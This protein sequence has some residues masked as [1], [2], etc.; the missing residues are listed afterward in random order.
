MVAYMLLCNF[1]D[2]GVRTIKDAPK[3]RTA[4]RQ[5][6]KKLGV[7]VKVSYLA[8]GPYDLVIQVEA[9]NDEALATYLLSLVVREERRSQADLS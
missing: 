9:P 6:A 4:A 3:R 2:Q 1:I 5:L 8:I 7:E